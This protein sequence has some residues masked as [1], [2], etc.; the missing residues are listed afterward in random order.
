MLNRML[1]LVPRKTDRSFHFLFAVTFFAQFISR[2]PAQDADVTVDFASQIRPILAN[3]CWTCHGPD[4]KSR[5]ADLRLDIRE[6][7]LASSAIVPNEPSTSKLLERILSN[8][9]ELQM[10]PPSTKKPLSDKQKNLLQ[11]WIRQGAKYSKHWAFTPPAKAS[12]TK[13]QLAALGNNEIDQFVEKRLEQE[14]LKPSPKADRSTLLRRVSLDLTGLPPTIDELKQ[15]INDPS[16]DA[17]ERAVDRLLASKTYAEKMAM[18]WLD[19]ARY[20]DTNGY[21]NDEDRTMWPWRD[22]VIHA[23]DRNMPFDQFVIEQLAGDLIPD[24]KQDQLIATGFLRNQ[25]HNTEGGIIQEEYR[26]EYVAD[27]VHT[28]STVFLGLSMQCARCHDHKFDPISQAEYYQFYSFFNSLDEKQAPHGKV[29]G[30]EPYIRVPTE[31]QSSKIAAL[32]IEIESIESHVK[33]LE[34]HADKN[35]EKLV[36]ETSLNDLKS[37]FDQSAL[38]H[39]PLDKSEDKLDGGPLFDSISNSRLGTTT[40][41]IR[42]QTG[43][44]Q[45]AIELE[46]TSRIELGNIANFAGDKPFSISVW[47]KPASADGMAILSKMDEAQSYRGYDLL[48]TGGKVEIHLV[49]KWPDN[50]IKITS[51]APVSSNEWHHIVATYDGSKTAAGIKLYVDSKPTTYSISQDSLR[52]SIETQQPFRI[53]LRER[54]L[55]YKGAI[56]ELQLFGNVLDENSVKQL[57]TFET[58]S[59]F[60]DWVKVPYQQRT[61][62]QRKQIRRF[63]LERI[64]TTYS[65]LQTKLANTKKDKLAIEESSASV[66]VMREMSPPRETFVLKRGQYDQPA[67]RVYS[68]VPVSLLQTG[69]QAP[70]DRMQL[71]K[72]LV[73]D[74]NPLTARVTV[75]RWWQNFFGTGIVKTAEDFGLTGDAPSH[76]ELLDFLARTLIE[77]G[78]NVK[79]TLKRIVMSSTYQQESRIQPSM[80][81]RDPENRLLARG[82]RNRLPAETIRDN[83]L[84]ISGLLKNRTGGPSVKPYQPAG[85][86]EDVTVNRQGK[87]VAD[88]GEGLY[89]RSLYTFWKRTCPPP[90]MMSFDAPMREVCIARRART[91]TPLQSLVLLNDP[92]YVECAR[93]LADQM[94][95]EGTAVNDRID[96]G[97]LRSVARKA[98]LEEQA[99]LSQ[100]LENAKQ[101]FAANPASAQSLNTT[102]ATGQNPAID[103][104]ELASWTILAS[105]LLNLDETI[106]K[107]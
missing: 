73:S 36:A 69:T 87:Y 98:T 38:L 3:H 55:P 76:P 7:A 104:V 6:N 35:V 71:A 60:A 28:V 13:M 11:A 49:N 105:T 90:S 9:P 33:E 37:R 85:L 53:G 25:G 77:S 39:F 51:N 8:E 57:A 74:T 17:Y 4:E 59:G 93:S 63:Y 29:I 91:N 99:I 68:T 83:A 34:A 95:H 1:R 79:A 75:N 78:W 2:S 88:V 40:G 106:S 80:L 24:H 52:D 23:F 64:D 31:E 22:W 100:V 97:F 16:S 20:A 30:V 42:W 43:K 66:M 58:V 41:T 89:R 67:E 102:G 50:A 72:W 14:H 56:D 86:W 82:P 12:L 54:S 107:R 47:A 26:V 84:A 15:F 48:L 5:A 61:E 44:K 18:E 70:K 101:R 96:A 27:R 62:E 94:I 46:G 10:P 21:N 19:L 32:A 45:D 92:T 81:D 103:P 65:A